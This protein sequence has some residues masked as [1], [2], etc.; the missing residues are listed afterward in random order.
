MC[1]NKNV[2]ERYMKHI[3]TIASPLRNEFEIS[4]ESIITKEDK[5]KIIIKK[6]NNN[7]STRIRS[8]FIIIFL[9]SFGLLIQ[10][11]KYYN[12]TI[13][14]NTIQCKQLYYIHK[15]D[16][17]NNNNNCYNWNNCMNYKISN[18]QSIKNFITTT[19]NS[20]TRLLLLLN[21]LSLIFAIMISIYIKI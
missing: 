15:C 13:N 7:I 9:F 1:D 19:T 8:I 18:I 11:Y 12:N 4:S 21:I 14:K 17:I 3:P 10:Y 16:S 2:L 20:S 5:K 6:N